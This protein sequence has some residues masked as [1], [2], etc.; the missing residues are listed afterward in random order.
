LSTASISNSG[1][2]WMK[3]GG[4]FELCSQLGL[5]ASQEIGFKS[6]TWNVGWTLDFQVILTCKCRE[7]SF[8]TLWTNLHMGPRTCGLGLLATEIFCVQPHFVSF[9]EIHLSSEL[10][11]KILVPFVHLFKIGLSHL[12]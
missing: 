1:S 11:H 7:I 10:V 6:E 9:F 12:P 3:S 8:P 2:L 5:K 4:G